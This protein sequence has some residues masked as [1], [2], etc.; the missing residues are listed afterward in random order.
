MHISPRESAIPPT[1]LGPLKLKS[2]QISYIGTHNRQ[3]LLLRRKNHFT[4]KNKSLF[5]YEPLNRAAAC[6]L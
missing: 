6:L 5:Y 1:K 3:N 4:V 2:T